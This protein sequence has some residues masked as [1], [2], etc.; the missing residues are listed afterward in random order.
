MVI[1]HNHVK[2]PKGNLQPQLYIHVFYNIAKVTFC[3]GP[4]VAEATPDRRTRND[5]SKPK[6]MEEIMLGNQSHTHMLHVWNSSLHV[7]D[8]VQANA[9]KY[10]I[11]GAYGTYKHCQSLIQNKLQILSW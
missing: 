10:T 9:G 5:V 11:H 7:G 1:F 6:E 8:F 2:L 3:T 4:K